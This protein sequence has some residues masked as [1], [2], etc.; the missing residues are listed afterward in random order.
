MNAWRKDDEMVLIAKV[1][2]GGILGKIAQICALEEQLKI[3]IW[4][5]HKMVDITEMAPHIEERSQS[6]IA[7]LENQ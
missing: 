2:R 3:A 7:D 5:L 6:V 1:N 4:E